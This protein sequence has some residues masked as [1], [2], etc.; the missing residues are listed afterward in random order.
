MMEANKIKLLLANNINCMEN[1]KRLSALR[2]R[3]WRS[4]VDR[5]DLEREH[6]DFW[7]Q[8]N[9]L[10]G[11]SKQENVLTLKNENGRELRTERR[12]TSL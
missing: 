2:E 12:C 11:S 9:R 4:L 3:W 8:V 7:K 1:R 5:V 6:R 10:M